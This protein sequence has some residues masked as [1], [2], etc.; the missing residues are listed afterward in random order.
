M[1]K[2]KPESKKMQ[3]KESGMPAAQ[4]AKMEKG[5]KPGKGKMPAMMVM[6]GMG[7]DKKKGGKGC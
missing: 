1:A 5:E 7:K 4:R 3:K 2:A 6:V